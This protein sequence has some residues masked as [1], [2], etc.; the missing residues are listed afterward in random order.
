MYPAAPG[1]RARLVVLHDR[2]CGLCLA[3]ATLLRRW[4]RRG[5]LDLVPLQEAAADPRAAVR[6]A[7]AGCALER[8]LHAVD[9]VDGAIV[10]GGDA[11]LA[12]AA[13]LPGGR[14]PAVV[15]AAPP[16]RWTVAAGYALVAANRHRIGRL[17]RLEGPGCLVDPA[18]PVARRG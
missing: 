9:E 8:E 1:D 11:V 17:L 16:F 13:R 2:D 7:A 3:A 6:G 18:V 14:V 4:D 15:L 12:I 5:L 10:A